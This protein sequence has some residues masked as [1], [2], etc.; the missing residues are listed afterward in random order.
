MLGEG[1]GGGEA[2]SRGGS[3]GAVSKVE[4]AVFLAR[5]SRW[6]EKSLAQ[7]RPL[8]VMASPSQGPTPGHSALRTLKA[9]SGKKGP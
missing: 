1:G 4:E 7:L 2:Q 5:C 9:A 3:V 8:R 6:I